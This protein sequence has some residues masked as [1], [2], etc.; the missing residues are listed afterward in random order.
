VIIL[1]YYNRNKKIKDDDI[2]LEDDIN[3]NKRKDCWIDIKIQELDII[4]KNI[5]IVIDE[6]NKI[7][8]L[9]KWSRWSEYDKIN[10]P[11]FTKMTNKDIE[12]RLKENEDYLNSGK[13]SWRI[14]GLK[15]YD[16]GFSDL[17]TRYLENDNYE[18]IEVNK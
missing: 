17:Y 2:K 8:K 10:T 6:L 5:H 11:I 18:V 3:L 4:N 16:T 15:L 9:N 7:I 14:F 13:P 1:I 12:N